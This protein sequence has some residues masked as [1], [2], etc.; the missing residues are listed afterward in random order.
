M[1]EKRSIS[2]R[3]EG[4]IYTTSLNSEENPIVVGVIFT[5]HSKC[6]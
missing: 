2:A 4:V 3:L 1:E 6:Y 5:K